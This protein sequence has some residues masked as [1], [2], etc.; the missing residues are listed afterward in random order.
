MA[1]EL[2]ISLGGRH[3]AFAGYTLADGGVIGPSGKLWPCEDERLTE[4][5]RAAVRHL[6]PTSPMRAA[7]LPKAFEMIAVDAC[8]TSSA[9]EKQR[10]VAILLWVVAEALQASW[11]DYAVGGDA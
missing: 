1:T 5:L 9:D 7:P 6:G 8:E 3:C 2:R 10:A 11:D 4:L